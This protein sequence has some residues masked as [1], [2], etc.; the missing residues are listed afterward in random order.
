[1]HGLGRGL[2]PGRAKSA[3]LRSPSRICWSGL[4]G[5]PVGSRYRQRS[6]RGAS[7][8]WHI[9]A[10]GP[11]DARALT[12]CASRQAQ[13][14]VGSQGMVTRCALWRSPRTGERWLRVAG[15]GQFAFGTRYV[16]RGA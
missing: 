6:A 2:M 4:L 15:T 8:L 11:M 3:V 13:R 16:A 9:L 5:S 12:V 14:L 7:P 10:Q 1:M